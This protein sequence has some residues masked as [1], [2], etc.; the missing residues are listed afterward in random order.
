M[1]KP[2]SKQSRKAE[3]CRKQEALLGQLFP[4]LSALLVNIHSILLRADIQLKYGSQTKENVINS[5]SLP[6][7]TM[8]GRFSTSSDLGDSL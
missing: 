8:A 7:L 2:T 3:A 6:L 5:Y 4:G 1:P